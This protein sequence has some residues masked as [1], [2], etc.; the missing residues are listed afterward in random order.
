MG[1]VHNGNAHLDE[2]SDYRIIL[3]VCIALAI[4]MTVVVSL[5]GYTRIHILHSLGIDDHIVFFSAVSAP[6]DCSWSFILTDIKICA[7]IY[8][9]LCIGQSAWGLGLPIK[10]RPKPNLNQYSVVCDYCSLYCKLD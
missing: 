2:V 6:P 8:S 3:G 9:G 5:R 10:L 4:L 7:V 1:W